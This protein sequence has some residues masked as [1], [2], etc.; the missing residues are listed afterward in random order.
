MQPEDFAWDTPAV[1]PSQEPEDLDG[2]FAIV[3][4][5]RGGWPVLT[6]CDNPGAGSRDSSETSRN[7]EPEN[8][9]KSAL[10][11][12]QNPTSRFKFGR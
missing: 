2:W 3:A 1:K 8:A 9:S 4:G 11:N 6:F 10:P 12:R 5:E 7:A